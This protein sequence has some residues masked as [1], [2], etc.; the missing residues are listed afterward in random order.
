M[1]LGDSSRVSEMSLALTHAFSSPSHT[2]QL[3]NAP[4]M[5]AF[6]A[7]TSHRKKRN[8]ALGSPLATIALTILVTRAHQRPISPRPNS[9]SIQPSVAL[10]PCFWA[11]TLPISTSATPC[12][13][14][15]TYISVSTSSSMKSLSITT[16]ATLSLLTDGYTLRFERGCMVFPK[17]APSQINYLE[18]CLATKGYYQCQHTPGLW[19]HV[20]QNIMFCLVVND[21]VIKVTNMHDMDHLVDAL[22][23]HYTVAIDMMGSLF[24]SIRLTWNYAKGHVDCHMPG[25]INKALMKY[26]HPTLVSPQHAPYKAAPIQYGAQVQRVEGNTT[27]PLTPKEIKRIQDINDTL[28]YY[29]Q[30]VDSTLLAGL[31]AITA[32]QSNGTRAVADACH[33]LLNYVATHPNAGI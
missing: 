27:Q 24:C 22:K 23:E 13:T 4:P 10:G 32:H 3:T 29:A 1:K 25:Y 16:F 20:R 19:R 12:R 28:L 31:S 30:G 18:K 11:S 2:F 5:A 26:Q 17:P 8:I 7:I 21:F 14:L 6:A 15:N 33:Q 9:S